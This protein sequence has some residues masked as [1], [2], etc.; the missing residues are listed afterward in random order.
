M[1]P[2]RTF[3]AASS[4]VVIARATDRV[5]KQPTQHRRIGR[6]DIRHEPRDRL[7]RLPYLKTDHRSASTWRARRRE[8]VSLWIRPCGALTRRPFAGRRLDQTPVAEQKVGALN[9]R[10]RHPAL[11]RQSL[12]SRQV[13]T[14]RV[15]TVEDLATQFDREV[16]T[17]RSGAR[18]RPLCRALARPR[19]C[20]MGKPC[21]RALV[22]L[23][24]PRRVDAERGH[25]PA[26]VAQPPRH[27]AD[28]DA[29]A[30]SA[31]WPSSG[32]GSAGASRCPAG[33]RGGRTAATPTTGRGA[34]SCPAPDENTNASR[35]STSPTDAARSSAP[36]PVLGQHR[37]RLRVEG[38][39][40]LLVGLGVLLAPLAA[41]TARSPAAGDDAPVEIDV[42]P[43]QRAQL[44]ASRAGRHRQP[45]E[46]A[47]VGVLPRRVDDPRRL[48]RRRRLRIG[49]LA[50]RGRPSSAPDWCR[51]SATARPSRRRRAG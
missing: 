24:Q 34:S 39:P 29:G 40:P 25:S 37:D 30:R 48:L 19:R 18:Q 41:R 31:R 9:G 3:V 38:Q 28:V 44:A 12:D 51:P 15:E 27:R 5:E 4:I 17:R 2:G 33:R 32:A 23:G 11:A 43:P 10:R 6:I 36:L 50:P 45:H 35:R 46:R 8:L 14:D 22:G 20:S 26:A 21:R 7:P 13:R 42:R 1:D 16:L 49:L 47:P